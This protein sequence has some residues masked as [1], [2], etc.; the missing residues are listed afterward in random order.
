M[1]NEIVEDLENYKKGSNKQLDILITK[2][3]KIP[4][5]IPPTPEPVPPVIIGGN[6]IYLSYA[7]SQTKGDIEEAVINIEELN[8]DG[9]Y[10]ILV[11][12]QDVNITGT[13]RTITIPKDIPVY[14]RRGITITTPS[15][16]TP[17]TGKVSDNYIQLQTDGIFTADRDSQVFKGDGLIWFGYKSVQ[18]IYAD[19]F[20]ITY[21]AKGENEQIENVRSLQK[22]V[23]CVVLDKSNR[24]TSK[25]KLN[26]GNIYL[27]SPVVAFACS[28]DEHPFLTGRRNN[29]KVSST[30]IKIEGA[31]KI[32]HEVNFG[33]TTNIY[34]T[35]KW[36]APFMLQGLRNSSISK[37]RFEGDNVFKNRD[38][39]WLPD[40]FTGNS[41]AVTLA[42]IVLR[43]DDFESG[44]IEK[45]AWIERDINWAIKRPYASIITDPFRVDVA[46]GGYN[47]K[48]VPES[49]IDNYYG[50]SKVSHQNSWSVLFE[51]LHI[52]KHVE[53]IVNTLTGQQGDTF[54]YKEIQFQ[55]QPIGISTVQDQS[56]DC[57]VYEVMAY[58]GVWAAFEN[59]IHGNGVM[60]EIQSFHSAGGLKYIHYGTRGNGILKF[61]S[62]Y[63]ELLYAVGSSNHEGKEYNGSGVS[64]SNTD[65]RS[66]R[67]F[68]A[69][70]SNSTIKL[71]ANIE[72][73][74]SE[75]VCYL[76]RPATIKGFNINS[77]LIA[78]Y[79]STNI[80]LKVFTPFEYCNFNGYA[81]GALTD[82]RF[83]IDMGWFKKNPYSTLS[84]ER[85]VGVS[86]NIDDTSLSQFNSNLYSNSGD[87]LSMTKTSVSHIPYIAKGYDIEETMYYRKL[88]S[89]TVT[90]FEN[91]GFV[92]IEYD[93]APLEYGD[94]VYISKSDK[95]TLGTVISN[96]GVKVTISN[97]SKPE[98]AVFV[99]QKNERDLITG[100]IIH[101]LYFNKSIM[102]FLATKR[103]DK[104]EIDDY[105]V[106][107]GSTNNMTQAVKDTVI[108]MPNGRVYYIEDVLE[109]IITLDREYKDDLSYDWVIPLNANFETIRFINSAANGH[110]FLQGSFFKKGERYK[111]SETSSKDD[112]DGSYVICVDSGDFYEARE[113]KD[114]RASKK[115]NFIR[116]DINNNPIEYISGEKTIYPLTKIVTTEI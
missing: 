60:P 78:P 28:L 80:A 24:A 62:V 101:K 90:V 65:T 22:A 39:E 2:Y 58:S 21:N 15:V 96:D 9:R 23:N 48:N 110:R 92:E 63:A 89:S 6:S 33:N 38:Y 93:K 97:L 70:I 103:G 64:K 49:T 56:R 83:P 45:I 30:I 16:S 47:L 112:V 113:G 10:R 42:K 82:F 52:E 44:D 98:M 27:N 41:N 107:G 76:P 31:E 50:T 94:L 61:D 13:P 54:V 67:N 104:I 46:N 35:A 37:I 99:S 114:K 55:N 81:A 73:T 106:L 109:S 115:A 91:R 12:D 29:G 4:E 57:K 66:R 87:P 8:K 72:Y 75:G 85:K 100:V 79:V 88:A 34:Y 3:S 69:T 105:A 102:P 68:P 25:L 53:G 95:I 51:D 71:S 32:K 5:P 7:V 84:R 111:Y 36:G 43:P 116:Y 74:T 40:G 77:S 17:I 20:G 108:R 18:E 59:T 19:W 11:I 1:P 26:N 86:L 14:V